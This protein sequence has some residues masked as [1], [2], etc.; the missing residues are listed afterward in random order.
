MSLSDEFRTVTPVHPAAGYV[1]GKRLLAKRLTGM[2]EAIPHTIYA[3][4][5]GGM[6]GVF[7][8]RTKAP[9][10][11]VINDLNKDVSTFFRV[12]QNH[13][14]AFMDMLRWQ[15]TSRDEFQRLLDQNPDSLTD[16]QRS[17][18]FLYLQRLSFGG[19]VAGRSFGI[20]TGGSARFDVNK[21]GSILED[22]HGRLASVTIEC[23]DWRVFLERWDRPGTL[24]YLDPPY[25]GTERYYVPGHFERHDH[26]AL[27]QA[28]KGLQG[29]FIMTMNDCPETR[30]CYGGFNISTADLTY[31][32]GG[33]NKSKAAREI[34]VQGP[35]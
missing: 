19:K 30:A 34:I 7:L 25:W 9:K 14:Q 23:L 35:S 13:Y 12:L 16:L 6:G 10:T 5:F 15:L 1:G 4:A 3:E 29:R 26:E 31:S 22:I 17:A 11:E 24:F 18:R 20:D 33:G 28:L 8:R 2:I 32:A 27:A 21:L